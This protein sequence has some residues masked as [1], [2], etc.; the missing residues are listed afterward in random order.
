M[1]CLSE[2]KT[3]LGIYILSGNLT[4]KVLPGQA[5]VHSYTHKHVFLRTPLPE[6]S[7]PTIPAVTGP[8]PTGIDSGLQV[9]Q[10]YVCPGALCW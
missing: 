7:C 2:I 8:Q 10:A 5:H 1:C 3:Q 4:Y 9:Y 6:S